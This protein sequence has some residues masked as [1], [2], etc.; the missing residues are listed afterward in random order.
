LYVGG[1]EHAVLHLLYARFWHQ[2]LYDIGVVDHSEPFLKLVHQGMI[3]GSDGEKMSKS[4]GNVINPDDIVNEYGADALRLYEMF[5]GP[6]EAVK[7]WQTSQLMGVVRFRERVYNLLN[8]LGNG[9]EISESINKEMHKTTKKV[10]EDIDRLSFNTAISTLMI[11][12]NLLA[13]IEGPVPRKAY[14]T[15][16]L[17]LAPF[18]PHVAEEC[19]SLMGNSKSLAYENWPVYEEELCQDSKCTIIVQING[20]VRGKIEVDVNITEEAVIE[21]AMKQANVAKFCAGK[22]AKKTIYVPG[23]ILNIVV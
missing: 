22:E 19:W 13:S 5:M 15:L 17:L 16:V 11:Y 6:L 20:K 9:N 4:R 18:A 2:V 7:P 1:Q 23:K 14:E 3:L 12:S 10:T 21:L 8:N